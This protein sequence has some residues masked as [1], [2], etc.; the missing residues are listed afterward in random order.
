[1]TNNSCYCWLWQITEVNLPAPHGDCVVVDEE[2]NRELNYYSD[3][4]SY[5]YGVCKRTVQQALLTKFYKECHQTIYCN[6]N[7]VTTL[8]GKPIKDIQM[9]SYEEFEAL[10][11]SL[12]L[13]CPRKCTVQSYDVK[14]VAMER[15]YNGYGNKN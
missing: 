9:A 1:M 14:H 11:D 8:F 5:S 13:Q 10:Y 6:P 7:N 4:F 3:K 15:T 12:P 2:I